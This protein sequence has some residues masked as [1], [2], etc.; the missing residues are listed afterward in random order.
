MSQA[1]VQQSDVTSSGPSTDSAITPGAATVTSIGT[2]AANVRPVT[3]ERAAERSEMA[4][5]IATPTMAI[6]KDGCSAL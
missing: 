5:Q 3:T 1:A 4:Y 2:V 6:M